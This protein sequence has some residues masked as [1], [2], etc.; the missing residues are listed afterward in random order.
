MSEVIKAE[1]TVSKEAYELG[2]GLV[3]IV[4]AAKAAFADG[5]QPGD[6]ITLAAA[7]MTPEVLEAIKGLDLLS[8]EMKENKAA[9]VTAFVVA[10]AKLADEL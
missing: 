8:Q 1:V 2:L 10:G 9:F 5:V 4:K 6:A 3:A 7:V